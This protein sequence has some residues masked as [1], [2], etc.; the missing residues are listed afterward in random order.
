MNN[1]K[2][3]ALTSLRFFAAAAIVL[4]H[5]IP[6]FH[7]GEAFAAKYILIQGVTFFFVLSGFILTYQYGNLSGVGEGLRFIY[8]RIAKIWPAHIATMLAFYALLVVGVGIA[9]DPSTE[10]WAANAS[11]LQAWDPTPSGYFAFNSVA[12]TLSVEL[13]FYVSFPV[14][15]T[16]FDRTWHVKLA[17]AA[18]LVLYAIS[19]ANNMGAKS[20]D[21]QDVASIGSWVY[22][23]PPAHLVE[24]VLG[25][26]AGHL[27]KKY[28]QHFDDKWMSTGAE[29]FGITLVLIGSAKMPGLAWR[30]W[31]AGYIGEASR[32]WLSVSG[33]APLYAVGV[34]LIASGKGYIGRALSISPLVKL[35][36]ISFAMYLAHQII[37]RILQLKPSMLMWP[38][39]W[40]MEAQFAYYW[41]ATIAVSAVLWFAIEK[42][43]QSLMIFAI[44]HRAR[45]ST[46]TSQI[47]ENQ[48]GKLTTVGAP[49][50]NENTAVS[51]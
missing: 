23:W 13:F 1:S 14:L 36:E 9:Y 33:S 38:T 30:M 10:M 34:F 12:W 50:V 2:L 41:L 31:A 48:R 32:S 45:V 16:N 6:Y 26:V 27:W 40:T 22:I 25:M 29:I 21:G 37:V 18:V 7:I 47:A 4:E 43:C 19:L 20:F 15:I 49:P 11:L 28:K 42:P 24:F 35:G 51:P 8:K 46:S 39:G 17:G 3:P 44:K 5:S